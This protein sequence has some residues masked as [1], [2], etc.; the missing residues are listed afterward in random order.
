MTRLRHCARTVFTLMAV[1]L[2]ANSLGH[3]QF[4]GPDLNGAARLMSFTGQIS[5][6]RGSDLWAL[7]VGDTVQPQQVIV[8]GP[9]GYGVFQVSDGSTFEVFPKSRVVFRQNRGDWKD[10]LEVWLGK[11]RVHIEH[12]GGLP[13]NNKVRTP[14]AV[15]SVRGTVFDVDVEDEDGTTLVLDEE[16][17]VEVRHLLRAGDPAVLNPG[18]YIRVFKNEPIAKRLVDKGGILQRA[19]RAL[20]DV[21]YQ[22]AVNSSRGGGGLGRTVGAGG[23]SPADTK[24]GNPAPPPP[25]PAPPPPPPPPPG[26]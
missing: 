25:P 20:S 23:G 7:N 14:S 19:A 6:V 26:K 24:N 9:D 16:G 13:N 11:V 21:L 4:P 8:T 3:A 15:I 10:L 5:Y 2:C 18:E 22:E 1:L 17:Q 12:A